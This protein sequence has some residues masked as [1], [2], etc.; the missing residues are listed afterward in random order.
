MNKNITAFLLVIFTIFIVR[1]SAV[2]AWPDIDIDWPDFTLPT[3]TPTPT[4]TTG[5]FKFDPGVFKPI[6]TSTPTPTSTPTETPTLTPTITTVVSPSTE[7]TG[8]IKKEE[9]S[10][11]IAPS[12]T[13]ETKT[14]ISPTKAQEQKKIGQKDMIYGGAIGVLVLIVLS[15]AWPAIKKFLHEKTA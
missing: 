10:T 3:N 2:Y 15:Q 4:P 12:S 1:N 14:T 13:Q 6:T 5:F 9:A 7:P 8:E 11:S